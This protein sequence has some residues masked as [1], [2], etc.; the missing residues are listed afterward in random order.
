MNAAV[1]LHEIP[2][3]DSMRF[4][5]LLACLTIL[6]QAYFTPELSVDRPVTSML[7]YIC[8]IGL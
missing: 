2:Y 4:I 8:F 6:S 7:F 3:C 1:L 5:L